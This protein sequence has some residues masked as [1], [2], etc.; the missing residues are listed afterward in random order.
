MPAKTISVRPR[1]S[2]EAKILQLAAELDKSPGQFVADAAE[3]IV[4]MVEAREPRMP[5]IVAVARALRQSGITFLS[6]PGPVIPADTKVLHVEPGDL[7]PVR[8]QSPRGASDSAARR[9]RRAGKRGAPVKGG[10]GEQ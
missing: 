8:A 1:Q 5:K 4:A 9:S 10:N 6:E 3:A 7:D 2:A